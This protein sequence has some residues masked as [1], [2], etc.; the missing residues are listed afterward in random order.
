MD[1]LIRN[2]V[3][4]ARSEEA[5][6]TSDI[7]MVSVSDIAEAGA[8]TFRP[9]A[10]AAGKS[11]A[12]DIAP[13]LAVSGVPD[14]IRRLLSLLLDNAVKYCDEGGTIQFV[15]VRRGKNAVIRISNPC[16]GLDASQ[17]PHYFDRFYRADSSRARATGGTGIGLSTAKAIVTRHHG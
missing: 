3:E 6:P 13:A 9:L 16:S 14:D 7:T 4:L 8:E 10:E 11:L 1:S 15:L 5:I 2:L 12:A 17:L